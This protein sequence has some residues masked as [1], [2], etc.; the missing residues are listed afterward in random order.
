MDIAKLRGWMKRRLG[1]GYVEVE[2]TNEQIDDAIDDALYWWASRMGWY[3]LGELN[4]VGGTVSYDLSSV[5]PEVE[6]VT[7]IYFPVDP[8]LDLSKAWGGFFDLRGFPYGQFPFG[9]TASGYYSTLVQTLQMYE[10]AN[11]IVSADDDFIYNKK[12]KELIITPEPSES[13]KAV[14]QYDTPFKIEYLSQLDQKQQRLI[15]LYSL[16]GAKETL[17]RVRS[18][19]QSLPA[20]GGDVSLDGN[21]LLGEA[22]DEKERLDEEIGNFIEEPMV[23]IG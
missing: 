12:T 9:Y 4:I 23:L 6:D 21:D 14:Y 3:V 7:D 5:T 1:D 22:R 16:A 10:T 17:G 2:L 20:A 8:A 18:K 15:K 19:Y 13:G 11:R